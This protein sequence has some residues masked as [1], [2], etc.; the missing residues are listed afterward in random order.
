MMFLAFTVVFVTLSFGYGKASAT[1]DCNEFYH[2]QTDKFIESEVAYFQQINPQYR[3]L[4][5]DI[6]I[7]ASK[8]AE[9][10]YSEEP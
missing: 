8:I 7:I 4:P 3:G 6:E 5:V 2:T 1:N 10:N 9:I